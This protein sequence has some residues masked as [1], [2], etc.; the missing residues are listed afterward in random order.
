MKKHFTGWAYD[1]EAYY[2]PCL[3]HDIG[4]ADRY[5]ASTKMNLE[6]KGAIVAC[7]LSSNTAARR[8]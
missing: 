1:P 6:F 3:F 7:K 4:I 2:L 8:T 5:L